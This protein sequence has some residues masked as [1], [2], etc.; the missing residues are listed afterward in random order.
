MIVHIEAGYGVIGLGCLRLLFD[1]QD[2]I[3]L[4]DR[5]AEP[6]RI[7][8][9][10]QVDLRA[11]AALDELG[12]RLPDAFFVNVVTED[13]AYRIVLDKVL[14]QRQGGGNAAF[15]FLI[16]LVEVLQAE[17]FSVAEELEKVARILAAGYDEDFANASID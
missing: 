1:L 5:D 12:C 13:H 11:V 3:S 17:F 7:F 14:G 10:L 9:R 16:G 6:L 4:D 8:D 15:A 2:A